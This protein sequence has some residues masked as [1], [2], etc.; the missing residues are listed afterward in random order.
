MHATCSGRREHIANYQ[1]ISFLKEGDIAERMMS[2]KFGELFD[3]QF[4]VIYGLKKNTNCFHGNGDHTLQVI[5][6]IT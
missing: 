3:K 6:Q 2:M 1:L 4:A 5:C